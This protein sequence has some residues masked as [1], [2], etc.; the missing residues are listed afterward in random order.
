M[1]TRQYS[2]EEL[3]KVREWLEGNQD[4]RTE[5]MIADLEARLSRMPER[6]AA[7]YVLVTSD[8]LGARPHPLNY[9][10]RI[11]AVANA[12]TYS[13]VDSAI[14]HGIVGGSLYSQ[15]AAI[16]RVGQLALRV[17][18]GEPADSIPAAMRAP[19]RPRR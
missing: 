1:A 19:P 3:G 14:D 7:Y 18:G 15:T 2:E 12:P 5:S 11:A 16:E 4:S 8:P 13:W 9:I 10:D 17:L 6:S